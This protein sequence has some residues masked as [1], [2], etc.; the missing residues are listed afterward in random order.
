MAYRHISLLLIAALLAGGAGAAELGEPRVS[1]YRGQAL[2]A[3]IELSSL[4]DPAA[5][6]Q[7]RV[8]SPDVYRGASMSVPPVLSALTLS[9]VK[10]DGKQFVHVTSNRPVDTEMLLLFLELGQ[11]GQKDVRLATLFLA[12]DPRPAPPPPP[13]VAVVVPPPAAAP[14][15]VAVPVPVPVA[16]PVSLPLHLAPV[17]TALPASLRPAPPGACKPSSANSACA[18]LDK[19]NIALQAKLAGLEDK[20]KQ[21][22]ATM[23]VPAEAHAAAP[24]PI[25]PPIAAIKPPPAPVAVLV[26]PKKPKPVVHP[27][28]STPWLWI[29]VAVAVALA[30]LGAIVFL[31]LRRRRGKA[32]PA[33]P[34]GPKAPGLMDG[35]RNRLMKSRAPKAEP[36]LEEA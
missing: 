22:Q 19:K 36:V 24:A 30:A 35:V 2:V 25:V 14:A 11:G 15:P 5:A 7:V 33:A 32:E 8:A 13:P 28:S 12:A 21:L 16:A 18:I 31:L 6:V 27:P 17:S 23:V 4:D 20:I 3:D 29:G 26:T 34:S 9:V 1:S 10:K